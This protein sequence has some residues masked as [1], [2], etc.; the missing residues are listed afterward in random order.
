M[1]NQFI[2]QKELIVR[3]GGILKQLAVQSLFTK[4][5]GWVNNLIMRNKVAIEKLPDAQNEQDN[6]AVFKANLKFLE[7]RN[8][9]L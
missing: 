1:I 8:A 9:E 6:I 4:L 3:G 5:T 7:G 2:N